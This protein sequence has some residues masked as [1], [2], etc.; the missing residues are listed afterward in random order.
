MAISLPT[1]EQDG[2]GLIKWD[3][4][5]RPYA[6]ALRQRY[7]RYRAG[8][9]RLVSAFGSLDAA[10]RGHE[11]FGLN[12]GTHEGRPGV[13]YREWAPGATGLFL[14]GDFNG[15]NRQ[16]HPL[17]RDEFGVWSIFLPDDHYAD[18]LTHGS[19]LKVH[20][21]TPTDARDRIPAYIRRVT[22]EPHSAD[23][24]GQYWT[25]PEPYVWKHVP[26][27]ARSP[28][29]Y[30]AHV[31]MATEEERIG[32]YQEFTRN[33]LPRI[34]E[35][36]YNAVQ[37]M[38]IQEHPYYASFGYHV[39]NF[40]APSSRFG[41]PEDLKELIDTAH[42]LGLLVVLDIVHSHSVKNVNE[43]LNRFDGTDHQ[44][45]HA[46]P[47]GE[48][49]AWDSLL[50]DYGKTEVLRFLLSN[51]RYWLEEFRFDGLRFDGVTSMMYLHHGFRNFSSYDDYL[52][53]DIDTDAVVYLQLANQVAH[54]VNPKAITIAEDVSGMVGLARPLDEGGIGFDYRLAMGIPDYWIKLLKEYRDEQW[55][56]GEICHTLTNRRPAE[57]HIA[58]A[59]SHDQALV[60]DKTIAFRL[61]DADMYWLMSKAV[62]SNLVIERGVALHK[63]IRLITFALGGEGYLNFMGNEFGH[64]EWIDFPREGNGF[65]YKY[66]RRQ[67]SLCDDPLLRYRDLAAFDRELQALD[68]RC[69]L[70]AASNTEIIH[71]DEAAKLIAFRRGSLVFV[72]NFH[73]TDS[74]PNYRIGVPEPSDYKV[75]LNTD[76]FWFGGHGIVATG[77]I[78]PCQYQPAHGRNQSIQ[79]YL[80]TRTAQVLA[81]MPTG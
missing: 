42:G 7:A 44:Y 47:R 16:S 54:E 55:N 65:S 48:H 60:G 1:T 64:P 75:V 20:V 3:P 39:S 50:F 69:D 24:A 70:L 43:G 30:E 67:W 26:P 29:I 73:P 14:T 71:T 61:M 34:A 51:V 66:A 28:R 10:S 52:I 78:Y 37:L 18:H 59:E 80:P 17:T 76:D 81:T 79:I 22:N 77:Q 15:W 63:M 41:T 56:M 5:L 62:G 38:A 46:G 12:K 19:R 8:L 74:H 23:W 2:T 36:G 53:H 32:T 49:P 40:F 58:Y 4:W 35:A 68:E 25:P 21:H 13:W 31:G 9:D 57:K 72:F 45:F 11:Y 33:V 6:E 27:Q